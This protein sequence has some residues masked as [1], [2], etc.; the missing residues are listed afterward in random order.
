MSKATLQD[1]VQQK[2][3]HFMR[4]LRSWKRYFPDGTIRQMAI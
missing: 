3:R 2:S 4:Y 1:S